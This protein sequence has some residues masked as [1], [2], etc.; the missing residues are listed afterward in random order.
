MTFKSNTPGVEI[1]GEILR[2]NMK[3]FLSPEAV[4]FLA[5]LARRFT[6]RRNELLEARETRQAAIDGGQFA[7]LSSRDGRHPR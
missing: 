5:D 6:A 2:S 4:G 1:T 3:P 7:E